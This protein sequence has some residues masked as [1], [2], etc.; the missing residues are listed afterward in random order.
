MRIALL[1]QCISCLILLYGARGESTIQE[2][3]GGFQNIQSCD[4]SFDIPTGAKSKTCPN[5]F[6]E[7]NKCKTK[8]KYRYPCPTTR[9]PFRRCDGWTCVP[10]TDE[11]WRDMPCGITILT[12][13]INVCG[14]V[15]GL[16]GNMGTQFIEKAGA[17]C[18]CFPETLNLIAQGIYQSVKDGTDVSEAALTA[19]NISNRLEKC[20]ADNGFDVKDNKAQVEAANLSPSQGWIVLRAAEIDLVTYAD[21]I[22]TIIPCFTPAG[23]QPRLIVDFF[24]N[25][26][27][28]SKELMSDKLVAV[29]NGWLDMIDRMEK[30]GQEVISAAENLVGQANSI[31]DEIKTALNEVCTGEACLEQQAVSFMQKVSNLTAAIHLVE[32]SRVAAVTAAKVVPEMAA[33]TRSTIEAAQAAPDIDYLIK[34]ITKRAFSGVGDIWNSFQVIQKLPENAK[35]IQDSAALIQGF[36]TGDAGHWRNTMSMLSEVLSVNW[37]ATPV[38]TGM[39]KIQ[40]IIRTKLEEPVG[41]LANSISHLGD[42]LDAFP[43]KDGKFGMQPGVVSYQRHSTVSMD[44]PCTR[45]K[46]ASF[47]IAGYQ[48]SFDYPEFYL[49]P[50]GPREIPWPNQHIPFLKLRI[51]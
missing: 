15:R 13:S 12:T 18:G 41:N 25:Y 5:K 32:D 21:L 49:C 27:T 1:S 26:F 37:D 7:P 28:K 30:K 20:M 3:C 35:K 36:I 6:F 17:I 2:I 46:R 50:Y 33:L 10:G 39:T 51:Q 43:I 9:K 24:T 40:S 8:A 48:K 23:C 34:L 47:S 4:A 31:S 29:L 44:V 16:A 42:S 14:A 38:G 11:I 22:T 19:I 45:Q